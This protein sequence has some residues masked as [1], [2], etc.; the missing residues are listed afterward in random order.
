MSEAAFDIALQFTLKWEG[1][2]KYTNHPKDRGGPT[3]YGITH[4]TLKYA[5]QQGIVTE[6]NIKNLSRSDAETIY[7][8]LYW[9]K[10]NGDNLSIGLSVAVFDMAAN[11]GTRTAVMKLQGI[12]N[13]TQDGIIGAETLSAIE[14][15][16]GDLVSDYLD[17]REERYRQIVRSD[18]SQQE[19][20][21]GWIN[22]VTSLRA[23]TD[24][25]GETSTPEVDD[26]LQPRWGDLSLKDS[27][28]DPWKAIYAAA[29]AAPAPRNPSPI[30]LDLDGD[31]VETT[32]VTD[33]AYFDHDKT[34]FAE[35][36]GWASA[37]DGLLVI[38]RNSDGIINDGG[39]LFGDRT[40]LQGGWTG[41]NGFEALVELDTNLDGKVDANDAAF[42]QL[43]I[44]QD[45][46]GD[47]YSSG[48]ELF[49]LDEMDIV[50]INTGYAASSYVDPNGNEH[51][52]VGSFTWNDSTIGTATDVWFEADKTY[53]IANDWLDVSETIA[54]LPDLQGYGN[55]YDLHQAMV[56]DTTGQLQSLVEQ[57][58][59]ETDT[60]IRNTLLEEILFKWTDSNGIDPA[61]RGGL[62]DARRLAVLEKLLGK[63][64]VGTAGPNP[65]PNAVP[66]L[67]QAYNGLSEMFYAQ[68]I[69]DT[70]EGPLRCHHVCLG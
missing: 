15:Y 32:G 3:K 66:Y 12:L 36:T 10:V 38:D 68:L 45:I 62:F 24:R 64:F 19:N 57:F 39:E 46:D 11:S 42:S 44:W 48:D 7:R 35:Q 47:G 21:R 50:S 14:S 23:Y 61:S 28:V 59:S 1:G 41:A 58:L 4:S 33:G 60:D 56:R 69:P 8:K 29:S 25:V 70:R 16:S 30:I 34:G 52:Q 17:A 37:D 31:G 18:P 67:T 43:R 51:K 9:N 13:V 22:R 5:N 2:S 40:L 54:D 49:T 26:L 27:D 63:D 20:L 55:V 65:V 53:T 6:N